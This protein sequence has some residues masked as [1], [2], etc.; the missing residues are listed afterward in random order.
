MGN[1][2]TEQRRLNDL[3]ISAYN[4]LTIQ[5]NTILEDCSKMLIDLHP[6]CD[7]GTRRDISHIGITI[8]AKFNRLYTDIKLFD[9]LLEIRIKT[10]N[11]S[12]AQKPIDEILRNPGNVRSIDYYSEVFAKLHNEVTNFSEALSNEIL[13]K[14]ETKSG[15]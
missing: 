14:K 10:N 3:R 12:E 8:S 1:F 6:Q 9:R 13:I 5:A 15:F 2:Q 11:I 7:A 4:N